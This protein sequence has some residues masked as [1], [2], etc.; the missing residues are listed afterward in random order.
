MPSIDP[1]ASP[2]GKT[3]QATATSSAPASASAARPHSFSSIICGL[4]QLFD[5]WWLRDPRL[6]EELLDALAVGGRRVL[7]DLQRGKVLQPDLPPEGGPQ[8]GDR[9]ADRLHR[10]LPCLVRSQ[11]AHVDLRLPEVRRHL[12]RGDGNEADARV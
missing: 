2:S 5:V 4:L 8:V 9:M 7:E 10:G 12:D 11:D 1:R 3:W 6:P